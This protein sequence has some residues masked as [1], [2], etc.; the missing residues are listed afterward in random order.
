MIW[1]H[2][3]GHVLWLSTTCCRTLITSHVGQ[4]SFVH[5]FN[6]VPGTDHLK[7]STALLYYTCAVWGDVAWACIRC[8]APVERITI[9]ARADNK[10][11]LLT[12]LSLVLTPDNLSSLTFLHLTNVDPL[13]VF[14]RI[15][16]PLRGIR[17]V[18]ETVV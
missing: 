11:F 12:T 3:N 18:D 8:P 15:M 9:R 1:Y 13:P 16:D 6:P 10:R 14:Y 7:L 17:C 4:I 5:R 2:E